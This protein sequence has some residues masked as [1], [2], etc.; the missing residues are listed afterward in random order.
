MLMTVLWDNEISLSISTPLYRF[1]LFQNFNINATWVTLRYLVWWPLLPWCSLLL[2][3]AS[4]S[5][6]PVLVIHFAN[7]LAALGTRAPEFA[8]IIAQTIVRDLF[9]STACVCAIRRP[10]LLPASPPSP[11][12]PP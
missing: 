3:T 2:L 1:Y 8:V 11:P 7:V 4:V 12:R 10:S 5:L 6:S 9:A